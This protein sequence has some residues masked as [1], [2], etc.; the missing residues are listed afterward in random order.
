MWDV[1]LNHK[2]EYVY[3][4]QGFLNELYL[5]FAVLTS[6]TDVLQQIWEL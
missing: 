2:D 4:V 6:E 1:S 3:Q 5:K